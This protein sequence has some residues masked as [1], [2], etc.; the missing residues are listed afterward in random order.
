MLA[1]HLDL[2]ALENNIIELQVATSAIFAKLGSVHELSAI[3]VEEFVHDTS[4]EL[5]RK[6][7]NVRGHCLV[8]IVITGSHTRT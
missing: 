1:H 2:Y 3:K 8:I 5:V 4:R 6:S 7:E